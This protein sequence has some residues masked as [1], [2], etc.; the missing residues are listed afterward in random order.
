MAL[1]L[2]FWPSSCHSAMSE[3]AL[4]VS[5]WMSIPVANNILCGMGGGMASRNPWT[6]VWVFQKGFHVILQE[7]GVSTH[8]MDANKMWE[9]LGNH[10]DFK[11]EKSHI[12]HFIEEKGHMVYLLPKFHCEIN[13]IEHVWAQAKDMHMPTATIHCHLYATWL[14]QHWSLSHTWKY[15]EPL[16]ES[17]TLYVCL[18]WRNTCWFWARRCR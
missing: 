13:P 3:D 10:P 7:K 16:Q 4:D 15:S 11:F 18:F 9:V 5:K 8:G 12:E 14:Y 6:I 2:D 17:L 1:C